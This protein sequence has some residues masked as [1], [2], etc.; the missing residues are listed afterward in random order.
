MDTRS[1]T[2]PVALITGASQGLGLELAKELAERGWRLVVD[3]R[4]NDRLELAATTLAERTDV[5]AIAGDV[6]DADHRAALAEAVRSIGRLD[7]LV[8][9]AS[10][11]GT[12]PLPRLDEIDLELVRRIYEVNV[13]APLA[14]A[15]ALLPLLADSQGAIVNV[16]SDAAVEPYETWG[17]YGSSKAALDQLSAILAEERPEV[18]V[19]V[20]DPGDM[21]T[22]MHQDAFPDED[23]SDRPL[24]ETV[25]P[26]LVSIVESDR[27]SGRL[28]LAEVA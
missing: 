18:R 2:R 12:S 13:L 20:V 22:E 9:N 1:A 19:W 17:G 8:N 10:T 6:A 16:T 7:L 14:L 23:I 25:A 28:R 26:R 15:Q 4:R 5:T 3:A 24:P 27:P 11:L 21:R